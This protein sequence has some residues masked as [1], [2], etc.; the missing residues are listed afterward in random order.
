MKT[1]TIHGDVSKY[2]KGTGNPCMDSE[3]NIFPSAA[4]CARYHQMSPSTMFGAEYIRPVKSKLLGKQIC[5]ATIYISPDIIAD[6]DQTRLAEDLAKY[7]TLIN[8]QKSV[9][10]FGGLKKMLYLC[11]RKREQHYGTHQKNLS[12]LLRSRPFP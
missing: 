4:D 7:E 5:T 12:Q 1:Y 2:Y 8:R 10:K 6:P 9:K 11:N 3:G